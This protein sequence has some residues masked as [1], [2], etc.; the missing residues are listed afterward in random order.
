M[1]SNI[2]AWWSILENSYLSL[3]ISKEDVK[4]QYEKIIMSTRTF[5]EDTKNDSH[6]QVPKIR[7]GPKRAQSQ[8]RCIMRSLQQ[9]GH[10]FMYTIQNWVILEPIES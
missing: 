9:T 7:I 10:N 5:I 6:S 8:L 4:S 3:P 2:T 1:F